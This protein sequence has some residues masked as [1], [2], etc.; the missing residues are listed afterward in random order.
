VL[1]HFL[2]GLTERCA[3]DP[4]PPEKQVVRAL[5]AVAVVDQSVVAKTEFARMCVNYIPQDY[6]VIQVLNELHL[7]DVPLD[8][9]DRDGNTASDLARAQGRHKLAAHIDKLVEAS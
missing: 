9:R 5:R 2:F 7:Y 8:E 4:A 3:V 1:Q 6:I